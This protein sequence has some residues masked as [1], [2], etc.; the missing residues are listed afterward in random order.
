MSTNPTL[1]LAD[2]SRQ[3][4]LVGTPSAYLFTEGGARLDRELVGLSIQL[5]IAEALEK[6]VILLQ[7]QQVQ[8][9]DGVHQ[10]IITVSE[11]KKDLFLTFLAQQPASLGLKVFAQFA[12]SPA[13]GEEHIEQRV[14]VV[15]HTKFVNELFYLGEVWAKIQRE[16]AQASA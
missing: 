1:T 4:I 2:L 7:A 6:Q 14:N 5:R 10:T 15:I 11:S 16:G 13:P 12:S 3:P 8:K 9:K